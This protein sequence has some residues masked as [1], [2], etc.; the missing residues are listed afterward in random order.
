MADPQRVLVLG[1]AAVGLAGC[2]RA[3]P[4]TSSPPSPSVELSESTSL[5]IHQANQDDPGPKP[6]PAPPA[7]PGAAWFR[8][9]SSA[10][11]QG[12]RLIC[13][14][15]EED[16]CIGL[17]RRLERD[18]PYVVAEASFAPE[19]SSKIDRRCRQMYGAPRGC[20]TP[21][22]VSF[23]GGAIDLL[24]ASSARFAF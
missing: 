21:L 2:E 18:D 6:P 5:A 20:N 14:R 23:D 9:L 17:L 16:P 10:Q 13:K 7:L 22:V 8:G 15:R 3:E 24:P 11:Q 1:I 12:V 4:R 19:D